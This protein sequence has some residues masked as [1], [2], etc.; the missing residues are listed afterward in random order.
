MGT[1]SA[2]WPRPATILWIIH[3]VSAVLLLAAAITVFVL[4]G[5]GTFNVR[6]R[7]STFGVN[8]GVV[9]LPGNLAQKYVGSAQLGWF[10]GV[11][12]IWHALVQASI[13]WQWSNFFLNVYYYQY[14]NQRSDPFKFLGWIVTWSILGTVVAMVVGITDIFL[15]TALFFT[16]VVIGHSHLFALESHYYQASTLFAGLIPAA[17]STTRMGDNEYTNTHFLAQGVD[18]R[19]DGTIVAS[20]NYVAK[21]SS[22]N[23]ALR[24]ASFLQDGLDFHEEPPHMRISNEERIRQNAGA[25]GGIIEPGSYTKSVLE[26]ATPSL[27]MD[28]SKILIPF[29]YIQQGGIAAVFLVVFLLGY[30]SLGMVSANNSFKWWA[31]TALWSFLVMQ[32]FHFGLAYAHWFE[33]NRDMGGKDGING[34]E[35]HYIYYTTTVAFM[36]FLSFVILGGGHNHGIMY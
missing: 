6:A 2:A 26:S 28:L 15:L 8:N 23:L 19:N 27:A 17:K 33:P 1:V 21:A 7:F 35:Y 10:I 32:S 34:Y 16:V 3:R 29:K 13:A 5:T 25:V 12:L 20:N 18:E 14:I 30:W 4:T 31:T 36:L 11:A 22:K 24:L 9:P